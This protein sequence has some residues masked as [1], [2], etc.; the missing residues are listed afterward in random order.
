[1]IAGVCWRG[2]LEGE[3]TVDGGEGR[4]QTAEE[5][6]VAG[7]KCVGGG[8]KTRGGGQRWFWLVAPES[9]GGRGMAA[10]AGVE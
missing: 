3:V 5:G 4:S 1:M 8:A 7:G 2:R 10:M 6:I 9:G